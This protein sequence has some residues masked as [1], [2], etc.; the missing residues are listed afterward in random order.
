[1]ARE[2][3]H[4]RW[5]KE[6]TDTSRYLEGTAK[7]LRKKFYENRPVDFDP[8]AQK[9]ADQLEELA[10]RL[11]WFAEQFASKLPEAR[12]RAALEKELT[13]QAVHLEVSGEF[14]KEAEQLLGEPRPVEA[15]REDFERLLRRIT[16]LKSD[17]RL[18][19]RN[20]VFTAH[21]K[22]VPE[23]S[24]SV[25][26]LV[27]RY[28]AMAERYD[29][30]AQQFA[31]QL[32][33]WDDFSSGEWQQWIERYQKEFVERLARLQDRTK[34]RRVTALAKGLQDATAG[35]GFSAERLRMGFYPNLH[36]PHLDASLKAEVMKL[37]G[38]NEQMADEFGRIIER[39]DDL[40]R[41]F[42]AHLKQKYGLLLIP[43]LGGLLG[44]SSYLLVRRLY[45]YSR[46]SEED[47]HP[48]S[49]ST[50]PAES[51][52]AESGTGA[53]SREETQP[54]HTDTRLLWAPDAGMG[55]IVLTILLALRRYLKE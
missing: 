51:K 35:F 54:D 30:M 13:R 49:S 16:W 19:R 55:V 7:Y 47:S 1:V 36:H 45:A 3:L 38:L 18:L 50:V 25:E 27:Q 40:P 31:N 48:A 26:E 14:L 34:D 41:S 44:G 8:Y 2:W 5:I 12:A 22:V 43:W 15:V 4:R 20:P 32:S 28:E 21:L 10:K 42:W 23:L 39:V 11:A 33:M 6:L 53:E 46:S 9:L 37:I 52:L 24:P 17:A 29:L